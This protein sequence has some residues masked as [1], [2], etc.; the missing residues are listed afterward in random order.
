MRKTVLLIAD[1]FYP[2]EM[3]PESQTNTYLAEELGRRGWNVTVWAGAGAQVPPTSINVRIQRTAKKWNL[4]EVARIV[5]WLVTMRPDKVIL[6]YFPSTYS[7]SASIT[8]IPGLAKILNLR[9][10]T[11]FT[12]GNR[13]PADR[14]Q[15]LFLSLRTE[16]RKLTKYPVGALGIS[17][18]LV[19]LCEANRNKLL[20]GAHKKL[21]GRCDIVSPPSVF[22]TT[23]AVDRSRIRRSLGVMDSDFLVAYFGV[24]YKQKGIEYLLESM[25]LLEH[26]AENVRLILVGP[27]GGGTSNATWNRKCDEYE[28]F[29]RTKTDRLGIASR[30]Q[31]L[32]E[33]G[34]TEV[35]ETLLSCD[36]VCLPFKRGVS[37][38]RSS[39]ITCAR[40]GLPTI[41]TSASETDEFLK[42]PQSG[43]IYVKPQDPA[44]IADRLFLLLND[45]Q[46]RQRHGRLLKEFADAH[47][48][49]ARFVDCFDLGE[50]SSIHR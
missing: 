19:F 16:W 26:K 23:V 46:L 36:V 7:Q 29:L 32:G 24:I 43:I 34:R 1:A 25:V 15:H 48:D 38:H 33:L 30:V 21:E 39:F 5:L 8:L 44:Q 20:R 49:N 2:A 12:N 28:E 10:I 3:P 4:V 17:E 14:L 40:L 50:R 35:V 42:D 37:N 47:F 31:W 9:C 27:K 22:P 13:P 41:T 11:F 6:M 45:P 18:R